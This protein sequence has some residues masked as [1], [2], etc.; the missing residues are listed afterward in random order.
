IAKL[1]Q[2][3]LQDSKFLVNTALTEIVNS[4]DTSTSEI[5]NVTSNSDAPASDVS[6]NVSNS[7]SFYKD[8]ITS[9]PNNVSNPDV[10][11]TSISPKQNHVSKKCQEISVMNRD[12]QQKNFLDPVIETKEHLSQE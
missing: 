1:E 5:T 10:S 2:K 12:N 7:D 9:E 3:Q 8:A 4:N 11:D 6:N